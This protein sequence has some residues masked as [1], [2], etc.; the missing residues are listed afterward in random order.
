L[1]GQYER[2]VVMTGRSTGATGRQ[3]GDYLMATV[4]DATLEGRFNAYAPKKK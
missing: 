3:F 1:C 4:E 2:K